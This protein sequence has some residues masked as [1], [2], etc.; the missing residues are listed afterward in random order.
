MDKEKRDRRIPEKKSD[1]LPWERRLKRIE[2]ALNEKEQ[3]IEGRVL[4][5]RA[6]N[7]WVDVGGELLAAP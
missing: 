5:V 1:R 7:I 6:E 3:L 4:E 2:E